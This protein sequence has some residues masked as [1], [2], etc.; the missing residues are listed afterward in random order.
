MSSCS[1]AL[2]VTG[3]IVASGTITQNGSPD[4]AEDITSSD[5][6]IG[7]GDIVSLD[8]SNPQ[9]VIKSSGKYDSN[10]IGAISTHPGFVTNSATAPD[11]TTI[12]NQVPLA[13]VGRIPVK[14]T[15]ENGQ[16]NAGDYITSSSIPGVGMKATQAGQV[17]GVAMESY[18]SSGVGT[19][20][21]YMEHFFYTPTSPGGSDLLTT[22][23]GVSGTT[24]L[25]ILNVTGSTSLN[26]LTVSGP[27][28]LADVTIGGSLSVKG[29]LNIFGDHIN[30][31]NNIRGF[32]VHIE[33]P[34]TSLIVRFN[35]P[36]TDNNYAA[37]CTPNWDTP[38]YVSD[39]TIDGFT[40]NFG[41]P[42][43]TNSTVDWL[44]IH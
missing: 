38:C 40:L 44:V 13:L 8:P 23:L 27:T 15:N 7:A 5:P 17:V 18:D 26:S 12:P 32:D 10:V 34:Y 1:E 42:G 11:G 19:I 21:V 36:Y 20:T 31:N 2:G 30:A 39:K 14:V 37:M 24:T 33:A 28:T 9:S 25:N 6:S 43:N 35:N 22:N 3:A 16:I 4:Y 41:V 29:D